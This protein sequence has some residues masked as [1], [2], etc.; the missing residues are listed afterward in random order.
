MTR[1]ARR[2]RL[3][4]SL[5]T[6]LLA[7]SL[8]LSACGQSDPR[9]GSSSTTGGTLRIA[10]SAAN[11]PFP[12]TPPNQGYEGYRFV[13]NNIYDALTRLDLD[14]ADTLPTPQPALAESWEMADDLMTYT[15]TLRQGVT[16]HDG[17]AFDADAVVFQLDRLKNPEFEF[18]S[19]TDAATAAS[20]TRYIDSWEKIDDHTVQITTTQE[21]TWLQWDLLSIYFPSP[22][23]VREFGNQDYNQHATGT[24]PFRMT[25][26][27][28]GEVMELTRYD[29]YWRGPAKL[30]QIILYPQ[31]EAASRLSMLQS[32][33]VN[34]AEV[35]SPD[36]MS[37]LEA[38]GYQVFLGKYPHG[39][40]PR[41]N[42][43]RE[44]F[45][46]NLAL[47]Q[48]LNY[49]LDREGA[50]ALMNGAGYPAK[51]WV[52]E[53][54]PAYAPDNPG[55][56]YDPERAKQLLAEAGY[57]PG[58]LTLNFGYTTGGSGNMFPDVMM[59]KLQADFRA[60]GVE[61]TLT[62]VEWT[63]LISIGLDGLDSEQWEDIDVLWASPAAG[64]LPTGY[65][66]SFMCKRPGG[67]ANAAGMCDE[68]VD[69]QLT[70]ASQQAEV[71]DQNAHLQQMMD[72]AVSEAY[73]LFWMHD[74]NL[75]VMS[76][77]VQGYVHPQSW[78]V[79]FTTIS[80]GGDS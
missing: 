72:Q 77:D 6:L 58:E 20:A 74:L 45:R 35:P 53:G 59:Q 40:M 8:L 52:Y 24:G 76:P 50:A 62:P 3:I 73:F 17:T 31:P 10:M 27:V 29:E 11:I 22:T 23:V 60:I 80:V 4:P 64:M 67:Q 33:E 47:R 7:V 41:F 78:W 51:Q 26:Y 19:Q 70:L 54:H 25:E 36:S 61:V 39:I 5:A 57:E 37:Q 46:D 63:V 21:Y 16:F 42:M 79:D 66:S 55:Y 32:G 56:S 68:V 18:Y 34:W 69:E 65:N 44:P 71:A 48:A 38:D 14:Q 1:P 49:A 30:D 43:F 75:R 28:D 12:S 2:G 13:G 9:A 15:F